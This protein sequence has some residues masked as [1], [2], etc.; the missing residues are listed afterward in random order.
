MVSCGRGLRIGPPPR[1]GCVGWGKGDES[2]KSPHAVEDSPAAQEAPA[3]PGSP[4]GGQQKKVA[5]QAKAA[6]EPWR[7]CRSPLRGKGGADEGEAKPGNRGSSPR[8]RRG[9]PG[10]EKA[11]SRSA[12]PRR[13][14]RRGGAASATQTEDEGKDKE[15]LALEVPKTRLRACL[16]RNMKELAELDEDFGKVVQVD[17]GILGD[18]GMDRIFGLYCETLTAHLVAE[19]D[20]A[21]KAFKAVTQDDAET[22]RELLAAGVL[23]ENPTNAGGQTLLEVAQ[24]RQK[25]NCLRVLQ[26]HLAKKKRL[27]E[28]RKEAEEQSEAKAE[29]AKVREARRSERK[30]QRSLSRSPSPKG[31]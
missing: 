20:V 6:E 5:V 23:P 31:R 21:K 29:R 3:S 16:N 27:E 7:P 11:A 1:A 13:R 15:P 24:D 17:R 10:A 26:E 12:S 14:R 28:M 4:R 8:R 9:G 19:P 2:Q 18:Q 30:G 25:A 22:L